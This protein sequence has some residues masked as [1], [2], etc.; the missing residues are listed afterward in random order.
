MCTL[1]II[2]LC[3]CCSAPTPLLLYFHPHP[4]TLLHV[5]CAPPVPLLRYSSSAATLPIPNY[6]L[7]S[8]T[9]QLPLYRSAAAPMPLR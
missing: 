5:Y 4:V 1:L 2:L 6:Y 7:H 8:T 3:C 9:T